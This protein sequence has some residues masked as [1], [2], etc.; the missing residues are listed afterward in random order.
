MK[1]ILASQSLNRKKILSQAGI[2]FKVFAPNIDEQKWI[3]PKKPLKSCLNIAYH[4]AL[5]AQTVYK[6]DLIIACDQMAYYKGQFFTKAKTKKKAIENLSL[7]N[8]NTHQL[9][10]GLY[11]LWGGKSYSYLSK[12][13]MTMRN[14]SLKQIQQYVLKDKPLHSAGSYHIES[15]GIL[16]FKKIKTEDFNAIQGL[17]LIKTINQLT[18]WGWPLLS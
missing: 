2:K 3:K 11:M 18:K 17:P 7:L 16:L 12:S 13:E 14:L 9:L 6:K 5:K 4:K 10:T 1:I 8:G 15:L